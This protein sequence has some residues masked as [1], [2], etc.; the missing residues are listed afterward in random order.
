[1]TTILDSVGASSDSAKLTTL[2]SSLE[3]KDLIE[4]LAAGKAK[5]AAMPAGG[6]GGGGGGGAAAAA[7]PAAGGAA[8]APVK[9]EEPE[10]E[11]EEMGFDLFGAFPL[12]LCGGAR[13]PP[14][15][16]RRRPAVLGRWAHDTQWT[17]L[18]PPSRP[19][20]RLSVLLECSRGREAPCR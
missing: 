1:V 18:P 10:E 2:L 19:R 20:R 6:G 4:V 9:A 8:A 17:D 3:G 7:A 13:P 15:C 12:P 16:G 5:M 14:A 11:E